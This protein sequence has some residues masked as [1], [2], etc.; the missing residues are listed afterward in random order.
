M[1]DVGHARQVGLL[2]PIDLGLI[3]LAADATLAGCERALLTVDIDELF[4]SFT[5]QAVSHNLSFI[6]GYEDRFIDH[7]R[8]FPIAPVF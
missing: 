5:V 3:E 8:L 1:L 6:D 2:P 4:H 7:L